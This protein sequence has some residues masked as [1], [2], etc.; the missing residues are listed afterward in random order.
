MTRALIQLQVLK[1]VLEPIPM[2]PNTTS[3]TALEMEETSMVV[4]ENVIMDAINLLTVNV[5][6]TS[7]R[8]VQEYER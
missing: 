3:E 2:L 6:E 5:W 1:V 4:K 7:K 8:S